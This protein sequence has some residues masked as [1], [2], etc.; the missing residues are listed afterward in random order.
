MT[1]EVSSYCTRSLWS[2]FNF[3]VIL[4]IERRRWWNAVFE[5]VSFFLQISSIS[6]LTESLKLI[7]FFLMMKNEMRS[8]TVAV[9]KNGYLNIHYGLSIFICIILHSHND[10][11]K[12][13]IWGMLQ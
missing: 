12:I 6:L 9:V 8:F 11:L 5:D 4:I 3:V 13:N 2:E 7:E 1:S 10:H